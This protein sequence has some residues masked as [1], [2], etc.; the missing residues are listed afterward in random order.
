MSSAWRALFPKLPRS[1]AISKVLTTHTTW[2][3]AFPFPPE[4]F[5]RADEQPDSVFYGE[6]RVNVHHINNAAQAA[7]QRHY[8]TLIEPYH[9]GA[10]IS[11]FS[12]CSG[13]FI[14]SFSSYSCYLVIP[15]GERAGPHVLLDVAPARQP[16]GEATGGGSV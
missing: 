14:S 9:G 12:L 7:V 3:A 5:Q 13:A 16:Q 11:L 6:P 2:P 10:F 4:S 1:M 15:R 8:L